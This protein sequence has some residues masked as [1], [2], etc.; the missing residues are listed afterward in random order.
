[1]LWGGSG[2][3]MF[4]FQ[5]D[6]GNDTVADFEDG[7]DLLDFSSFGFASTTEVLGLA[8]QVGTDVLFSLP[9]DAT[10]WLSHFDIALLGAGDIII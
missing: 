3:D 1:V 2:M 5:P 4:I 9:G 6:G 8:A 10:V 7:L